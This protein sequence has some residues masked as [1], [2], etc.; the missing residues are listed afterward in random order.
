MVVWIQVASLMFH[1]QTNS[2]IICMC[3]FCKRLDNQVYRELTGQQPDGIQYVVTDAGYDDR[4]LYDYSKYH[5]IRLVCP[6]R[7]YRRTKSERLELISFY[8]SRKG[9]KIYRNRSVSIEPLFCIIKETFGIVTSP[10]RGF[11]NVSS[12]ILMCVFVY[13]IVACQMKFILVDNRFEKQL[14][15][16]ARAMLYLFLN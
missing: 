13:Q 4:K 2:A 12:Y 8:K 10:V 3:N 1:W 7:R 14:I 16:R 9:Q 15:C 11:D 5:G 6:V